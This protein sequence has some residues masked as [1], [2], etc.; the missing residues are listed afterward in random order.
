MTH[1]VIYWQIGK[2]QA[3]VAD[4]ELRELLDREAHSEVYVEVVDGRRLRHTWDDDQH[5]WVRV[6]V[7]DRAAA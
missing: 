4:R 3:D 5:R 1:H 7:G 2:R 6:P